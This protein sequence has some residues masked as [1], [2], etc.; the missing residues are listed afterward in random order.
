MDDA[1]LQGI[2]VASPSV[3][4]QAARDFAAALAETPEL[5]AYEQA[6]YAFRREQAQQEADNFLR[7]I[8]SEISQM[9]GVDFDRVRRNRHHGLPLSQA[10]RPGF[11]GGARGKDQR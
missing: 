1:A 8:N 11:G 10:R 7:E 3:V 4:K 5:K 6:D 9:L 2:E